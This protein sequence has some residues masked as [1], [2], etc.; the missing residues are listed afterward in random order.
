MLASIHAYCLV[1]CCCRYL[2]NQMIMDEESRP[3][4]CTAK[5]ACCVLCCP[6]WP[7]IVASKAVMCPP[8]PTYT[9]DYPESSQGGDSVRSPRPV[10]FRPKFWPHSQAELEKID[11]FT[12]RS[13]G[14]NL[15]CIYVRGFP[16]AKFT[17]LYSHAMH[18][19]IG[20]MCPFLVSL[21]KRINCN[22]FW[23]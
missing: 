8:V 6:P 20:N 13:R 16:N 18:C 2:K 22:I 12:I 7:T 10:T 9:I 19:D 23:Y 17:L 14:N 21:A 5:D 1:M 15:V 11:A 3:K 4:F